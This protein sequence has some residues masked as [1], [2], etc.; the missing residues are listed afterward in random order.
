MMSR[1]VSREKVFY[2]V[3]MMIMQCR[4]ESEFKR[5]REIL[6]S[7]E[8]LSPLDKIYLRSYINERKEEWLPNTL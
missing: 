1:K 8:N 2:S 4:K 5:A 3:A 6:E 7:M